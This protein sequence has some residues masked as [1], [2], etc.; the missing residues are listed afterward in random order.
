MEAVPLP[1]PCC[2]RFCCTAEARVLARV[3]YAEADVEA[4]AEA[5]CTRARFNLRESKYSPLA[6]FQLPQLLCHPQRVDPMQVISR[7]RGTVGFMQRARTAERAYAQ[8]AAQAAE[9]VADFADEQGIAEGERLAWCAEIIYPGTP[10]ASRAHTHEC[11]LLCIRLA[12]LG[13]SVEH[14]MH[15]AFCP[16]QLQAAP[17]RHCGGA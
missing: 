11:V 4:A 15:R 1:E 12:G 7:A 14:E 2:C 13:R 3:R 17:P 10:P 9:A 8:Q 16:P 6:T 5:A